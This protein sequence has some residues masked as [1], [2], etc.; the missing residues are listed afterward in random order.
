MPAAAYQYSSDLGQLFQVVIPTD[1]ADAMSIVPAAGTEPYLDDS[2]SPRYANYNNPSYGSRRALVTSQLALSSLSSSLIVEG[3]N[4]N[5]GTVQGESRPPYMLPYSMVPQAFSAAPGPQGIP[6]VGV[7]PFVQTVS[8]GSVSG[9]CYRSAPIVAPG[10]IVNVLYFTDWEDAGQDIPFPVPYEV[11]PTTIA[12]DVGAVS[13]QW[14]GYSSVN[15]GYVGTR[16]DG[17][18]IFF[19]VV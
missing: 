1:F 14:A 19:G 7:K 16:K 8:S 18:L 4:W 11:N 13:Y 2:I 17:Y 9:Q 3:I 5:L 12:N 15:L 6:G 10:M